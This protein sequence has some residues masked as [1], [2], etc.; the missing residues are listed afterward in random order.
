MTA[1]ELGHVIETAWAAH[2]TRSQAAP[3]K[4]PYVYASSWRVCDRRMVLELTHGDQLPAWDAETLAKFARGR[5]R[6]RDILADLA[7]IGR[8]AEPPFDLTSQQQRF[9]L[10]D[11]KGRVVI[12]GKVDARLKVDGHEAPLEVKAWSPN[13]V[14]RVE[15]F[16]DLF[17]GTWTRAGAYQLLAYLYGASEPYGF[18]VLDRAGIP[19]VLPVDLDSHLERVEAFLSRAEGAMNHR[20]NG[21]LPDYLD[22]DAAECQRCPFYG[23]ACNPPLTSGAAVILT[24][25]DLEAA[26]ERR[27]ALKDAAREYDAVDGEVK[28]RLRGVER[29]IVGAFSVEGKWGK[30]TKL[31]LPDD[32]RAQYTKVDPR[33]R[34]TLT[35]TKL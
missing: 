24:D 10:T 32:V 7:R 29:G 34:F 26:L 3:T 23:A 30:S 27:E 8:D 19:A 9:E 13:L 18:M 25:P 20:D 35:I 28:K 5:D 33:G 12:V 2:L 21:T 6:E 1:A 22:G 4:R 16:D 31:E 17:D 11:R 15:R 14:A